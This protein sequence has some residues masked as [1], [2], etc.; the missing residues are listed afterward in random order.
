MH[1][2]LYNKTTNQ[3]RKMIKISFTKYTMCHV[4]YRIEKCCGGASVEMTSVVVENSIL[5]WR[6]ASFYDR[7]EW[8]LRTL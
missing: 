8:Y 4:R 1:R 6:R 3:M 5:E 7:G 2:L